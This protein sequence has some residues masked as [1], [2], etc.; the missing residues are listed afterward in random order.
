MLIK[1]VS[2][3][4][5]LVAGLAVICL[6]QSNQP[7]GYVR[8]RVFDPNKAVIPNVPVS[9]KNQVTHEIFRTMTDESGSF[10][11]AAV[12]PGAYELMAESPYFRTLSKTI[13]IEGRG[14]NQVDL[15]LDFPQCPDSIKRLTDEEKRS[16][17]VCALH[18]RQLKI[19]VV[20]IDYG[21]IIVAG[22]DL[23]QFFPNS[24]LVYYGGCVVHCYREAEVLFCPVCRKME[25]K[26][27]KE[28]NVKR[29]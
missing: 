16:A 21:L 29:H 8:G 2:S 23:S 14:E 27:R 18:H 22:D 3:I 17:T 1:R 5:V 26:M 12:S 4:T 9:L 7:V 10:I 11:F 13:S 19:G 28:Q 25:S 6:A 15:T 24:K 20:P